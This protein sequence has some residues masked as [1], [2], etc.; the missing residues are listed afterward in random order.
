MHSPLMPRLRRG[1]T[2]IELLVV[3]AIIAILIGLLLPAVQKV[4]EAASRAQSQNNL[5]QI[6]LALHNAHDQLGAFPPIMVNQWASFESNGSFSTTN[7]VY[8]GP[9]LPLNFSTRGGDKTTFFYALLPYIEQNNLHSSLN[10]SNRY[11]IMAQ[12]TDDPNKMVGSEHIKIYQAPADPSP[13]REINWS[14]PYTGT[15]SNQIFKQTLTSYAPNA[16]VFGQRLSNGSMSI[17]QVTWNNAGGGVTT[18]PSITDGTANT[19]FVVEKPMVTGDATVYYRDWAILNRTNGDDGVNG[20]AYTDT[21]PEGTAFFGCNCN[22]PRVSWDDTYG[23]WWLGS[24]Q[25]SGLPFEYFQPPVQ[26]PIPTQ[27]HFTNIYPYHTGGVQALMGD[28]S[29]RMIRLGI[30]IQAWSAAVT[31][32]GGE[33]ATLD[34]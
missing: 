8:R 18:I 12:R 6:G 5:K 20:W 27:Q 4:R 33:V 16:R 25:F 31:H 11:Y 26:R 30:S 9:Y 19:I 1:F 29:V 3:I 23:Q 28:G 10:S 21:P 7:V 2:L 32:N 34:N 22:D 24:C 17:W 13:Y 14:W 15:G